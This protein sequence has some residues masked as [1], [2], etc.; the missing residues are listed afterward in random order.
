MMFCI[1]IYISFYF[2]YLV[3]ALITHRMEKLRWRLNKLLHS[4]Y[5]VQLLRTFKFLI[6]L[7]YWRRMLPSSSST[8]LSRVR[9][10]ID[11][12]LDWR[13]DLLTTLTHDS[14]LHLLMPSSLIFTVYKSLQHTLNI[15]SPLSLHG[16]SPLTASNSGDS[17][18]SALTSLPTA[19]TKSS[20]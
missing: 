13:L 17:S 1:Y 18:A 14:W 8:V 5:P 16:R 3:S 11:A 7:R 15:S 10:T 20:L 9:V 12:V 2:M 19:P 4:E 6:T